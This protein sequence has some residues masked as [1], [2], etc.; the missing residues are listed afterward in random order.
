MGLVIVECERMRSAARIFDAP[1]RRG[2]TTK[3]GGQDGIAFF[4]DLAVHRRISSDLRDHGRLRRGQADGRQ[5]CTLSAL[6][7]AMCSVGFGSGWLISPD[8]PGSSCRGLSAAI[9]VGETT[10]RR[11]AVRNVHFSARFDVNRAP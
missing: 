4:D 10:S 2:G 6:E 9:R 8:R 11:P 1:D 3:R 5:R 7:L